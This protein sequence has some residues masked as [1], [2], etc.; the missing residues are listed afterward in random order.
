MSQVKMEVGKGMMNRSVIFDEIDFEKVM[1]IPE[2]LIIVRKKDATVVSI[3]P[4]ANETKE[5]ILP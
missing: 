2:I 4:V 5:L 3:S 1:L